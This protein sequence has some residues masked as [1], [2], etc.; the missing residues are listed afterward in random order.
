M[1]IQK[2]QGREM[3]FANLEEKLKEELDLKYV[4]LTAYN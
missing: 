1:R 2:I 4:T 3:S